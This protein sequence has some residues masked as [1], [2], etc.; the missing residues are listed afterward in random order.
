MTDTSRFTIRNCTFAFRCSANWEEMIPINSEVRF[1]AGGQK[2]V[3]YCLNDEEIAK[4]VKLNRC[5]AF[6]RDVGSSSL[7]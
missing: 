3:F 1:C 6:R 7:I 2:E 4:N 5:V